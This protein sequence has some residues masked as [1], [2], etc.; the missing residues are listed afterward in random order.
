MYYYTVA[1]WLTWTTTDVKDSGSPN[2]RPVATRFLHQVISST[3]AVCCS[4]SRQTPCH[5][6][7]LQVCWVLSSKKGATPAFSYAFWAAAGGR[8]RGAGGGGGRGSI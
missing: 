6:L 4:H 8:G 5:P 1:P 7:R 2:G 3:R